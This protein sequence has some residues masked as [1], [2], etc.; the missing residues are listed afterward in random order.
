M[1]IIGANMKNEPNADIA[2]DLDAADSY[3]DWEFD[4]TNDVVH[5]FLEETIIPMV[6]SFDFNQNDENYVPGVACFT[7]FTRMINILLEN[8]WTAEELKNAVEEFAV[9]GHADSIH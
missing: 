6:E 4:Y 1:S 8:G 5:E 2:D 3:E 7:L 9:L